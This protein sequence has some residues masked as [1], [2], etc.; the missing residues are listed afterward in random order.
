MVVAQQPTESLSTHHEPTLMLYAGPWD[1]ELVPKT[2]VI[3]L[4]VVMGQVRLDH[5]AER[6]L[7]DHA[8][9]IQGFVFDRADEPLAIGIEIRAPW[10]Q[11]DRLPPLVRSMRSKP[12]SNFVSRS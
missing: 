12:Y 7:S 3:S 6:R 4:V 11:D 2:L 9:L 5:R 10:R 8:H 1:H